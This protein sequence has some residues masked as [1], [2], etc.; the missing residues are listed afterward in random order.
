VFCV[1]IFKEKKKDHREISMIK[2]GQEES[3]CVSSLVWWGPHLAGGSGGFVVDPSR[4]GRQSR[5]SSDVRFKF[6]YSIKTFL[7]FFF[8]I[9]PFPNASLLAPGNFGRSRFVS[10]LVTKNRVQCS[11]GVSWGNALGCRHL[12]HRFAAIFACF[13]SL[14][15]LLSL[16]SPHPAYPFLPSYCLARL[17]DISFSFSSPR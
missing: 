17:T 4:A 10:L 3:P 2:G 12:R 5:K 6:R 11:H 9:Q 1:F 8:R 16:L 14:C 15:C 13:V 7:L